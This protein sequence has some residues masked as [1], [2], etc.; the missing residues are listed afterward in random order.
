MRTVIDEVFQYESYLINSGRLTMETLLER[1]SSSLFNVCK[2]KIDAKEKTLI[3]SG[4]GYNDADALRVATKLAEIGR[5][6]SIY[7]V[8]PLSEKQATH[9]K[10]LPKMLLLQ[11]WKSK[12]N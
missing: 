10:G 7:P 6:V 3:I 8:F 12:T 1:A 5:T 2:E 4:K 11:A 9:T